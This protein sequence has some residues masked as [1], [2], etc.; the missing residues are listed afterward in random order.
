[1]EMVMVSVQFK[2]LRFSREFA[3]ERQMNARFC[4]RSDDQP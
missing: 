1:M 3:R 2:S 4:V